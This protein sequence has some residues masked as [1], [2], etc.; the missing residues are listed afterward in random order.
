MFP[1]DGSACTNASATL[2]RPSTWRVNA[3]VHTL[4]YG[5]NRIT[6]AVNISR[7][8]LMVENELAVAGW[9][10]NSSRVSPVHT[11]LPLRAWRLSP[12]TYTFTTSYRDPERTSQ[13]LLA[14]VALVAW[15]TC[16][17]V[18]LRTRLLRRV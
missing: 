5:T 15:L 10:A 12:G 17:V 14:I 18:L 2:A 4:S 1:C 13:L 7:P 8:E 6:Y 3:S 9:Q 16:V 11:R